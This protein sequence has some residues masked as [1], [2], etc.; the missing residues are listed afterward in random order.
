MK[1]GRLDEAAMQG[2]IKA[3]GR[4]D[5][6]ESLDLLRQRRFCQRLRQTVWPSAVG[7]GIGCL[8]QGA[9]WMQCMEYGSWAV[10]ERAERTVQGYRRFRC[11]TCGKQFNGRSTGL[12]N[13]T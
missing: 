4:R 1:P 7:C 8:W 11:R 5:N 13:R 3:L 10:S 6:V 2:V 12:L 9:R